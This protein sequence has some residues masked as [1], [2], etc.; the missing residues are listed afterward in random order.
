MDAARFALKSG[1][2][3]RPPQLPQRFSSGRSTSASIS[4]EPPQRVAEKLALPLVE[5]FPTARPPPWA[6][7]LAFFLYSNQRRRHLPPPRPT[8]TRK[9]PDPSGK[10]PVPWTACPSARAPS[11]PHPSRLPFLHPSFSTTTTTPPRPIT[12]YFYG[13][14]IG[15]R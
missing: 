8:S 12:A 11:V 15:A 9:G 2:P 4:S 10:L 5:L 1:R 3:F 13:R 14:P 7:Q 6:T